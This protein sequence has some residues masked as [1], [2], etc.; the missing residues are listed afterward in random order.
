MRRDVGVSFENSL[1]TAF[2]A[3]NPSINAR[4]SPRCVA[5]AYVAFD[6]IQEVL[7]EA[8]AQAPAGPR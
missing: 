6:E 7:M 8:A 3:W 4:T 5:L 1:G 2:T